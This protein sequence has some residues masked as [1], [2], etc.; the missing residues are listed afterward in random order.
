MFAHYVISAQQRPRKAWQ[1]KGMGHKRSLLIGITQLIGLN[2][3]TSR[4]NWDNGLRYPESSW[5]NCVYRLP[6]KGLI[7]TSH[8][9]RAVLITL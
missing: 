8:C 1:K 5:A 6:G 2:Q 7:D 3:L 4:E 9:S